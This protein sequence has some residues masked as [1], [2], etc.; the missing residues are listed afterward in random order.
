MNR[1]RVIDVEGSKT[2]T[3]LRCIL[4]F[5]LLDEVVVLPG[6]MAQVQRSL[7]PERPLNESWAQGKCAITVANPRIVRGQRF[8]IDVRY[9]NHQL[10]TVFNPFFHPLTHQPAILGIFDSERQYIGDLLDRELGSFRGPSLRDWVSIGAQGY[11]GRKLTSIA[12][13][14][15][16]TDYNRQGHFLPAGKYYLQMIYRR[17]FAISPPARTENGEFDRDDYARWWEEH[18]KLDRFRSNIL[19]IELLDP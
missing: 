14:V 5:L 19:E 4:V 10:T 12:G 3:A 13:A 1:D 7:E 11:A 17:S 15:P 18:K 8:E 9:D 16:G 2:V 6:A